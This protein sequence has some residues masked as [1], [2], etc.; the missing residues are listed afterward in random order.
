[1]PLCRK[2]TYDSILLQ[3]RKE[4]HR[5]VAASIETLFSDRLEE[6]YILL[7]YHYSR[8]EDWEKA[9]GYLFKAGDQ[10]GRIAADAEALAHYEQA[11]EAYGRVF[12]DKWDPF[13]RAALERKMGEA[14]YRRGD[15]EQ[16]REYLYR[17]LASL[18]RPY[19]ETP[20][21]VRRALVRQVLVQIGHRVFWWLPRRPLSPE[22]VRVTEERWWIGQ[23]VG[24]MEVGGDPLLLLFDCLEQ[25]NACERAGLDWPAD[26]Y[27]GLLS[28]LSGFIPLRRISGYYSRRCL[29]RVGQKPRDDSRLEQWCAAWCSFAA[30]MH[31]YIS[32]GD[33]TEALGHLRFARPAFAAVGD[34][35]F[36][37]ATGDQLSNLLIERGEFEEALA[38]CEE[39][40]R[41]GHETGDRVAEAWGQMDAG[42]VLFAQGAFEQAE[43]NLRP[44]AQRLRIAQDVANA[45]KA[46]TR[47]AHCYLKQGRLD[48]AR[49]ILAEESTRVRETGSRGYFIRNVRT[50]NAA[51]GVLALERA[52]SAEKSR[53]LK[54]AEKACRELL[55]HGKADS[56]ALAP[57][58]R[59]HGTYEW[60]RGN[61]SQ[62]EKWWRKS[63]EHAERLGA[64]YEGALTR[65][66]IGRRVGDQAT[67]ETAEVAFAEMGAAFD[68][69]E[70][71]RLLDLPEIAEQAV[72]A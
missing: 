34:T 35:R 58:Y 45:A 71:R 10:A 31:E 23:F 29:R 61:R 50:G 70:A 25:L 8:A 53:A 4:L 36:W 20:T 27:D 28:F 30:G 64:R 19:P 22:A 18:G 67:L 9:Q 43:A 16:A 65:L 15:H 17:A 1:M 42:D 44:A 55:K 7:A 21:A 62:A 32:G 57:A 56:G 41:F 11:I 40:I 52:G 49:A 14:L 48:E 38:L 47:I 12:G 68:L 3:R 60:L 72:V 66:E 54:E 26:A 13:Q 2:T 46:A 33:W 24:M 63:L 37:S 5:K 6:F 59:M 69:A 39:S 51:M